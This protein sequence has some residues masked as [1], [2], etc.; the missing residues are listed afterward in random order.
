MKSIYL[1]EVIHE[2]AA[3]SEKVKEAHLQEMLAAIHKADIIFVAGAGRSG[4]VAR[5]FANRLMHLGFH[6][7]FVGEPTTTCIEENDLLILLSGSGNTASLVSMAEKAKS[8]KAHLATITIFPENK[9]GAL[10]D[11]IIA[12]PGTSMKSQDGTQL[13]SIQMSG[14]LFEQLSWLVCDTLVL[15]LMNDTKQTSEDLFKRH[16]NLE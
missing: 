6:V 2:L 11:T 4:F 14:S 5:A 1:S 16:A 13:T 10:A 7:Y 9:I 12:L 15:M 8:L 3:Y